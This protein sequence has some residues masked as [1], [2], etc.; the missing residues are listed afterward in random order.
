VRRRDLLPDQADHPRA[1]DAY[2]VLQ[3][4]P[5]RERD[6]PIPSLRWR[7]ITFIE[8][9]WDRFVAAEEINDLYIS[10]ADGLY[11]TLK[12][13]GLYPERAWGL[14]EGS[15][16]YEIDLAVPCRDGVVCVVTGDR[17]APPGALRDPD[18]DAVLREV[19][20]RGGAVA[21]R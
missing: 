12:D 7:R 17:P 13:T 18:P 5:L 19:A 2:Y 6:A 11:V 21:P 15:V 20:R 3:L 4:G 10:G 16:D 1:D 9:S 8:S 14:R